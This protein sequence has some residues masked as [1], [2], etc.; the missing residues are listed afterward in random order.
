MSRCPADPVVPTRPAES[1]GEALR[2]A[3][4]IGWPVALK[5]AASGL[6]HKTEVGGIVLDL[7]E[8]EAL[9]AAYRDVSER[10]G[11]HVIVTA[12]V[13]RGVEVA[14]GV[15][16]DDQFGAMVMVAAGGVL[17]ELLQERRFVLP[18][19][20]HGRALEILN[21]LQIGHL[22][23]GLRGSPPADLDEVARTVVALSRLADDLGTAL[24][25]IDVNPL[26]AG[27]DGCVAVDALVIPRSQ[28]EQAS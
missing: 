17:I 4:E 8:E 23:R 7:S 16:R 18:P 22:L 12:M 5:T 9:L 1:P 10:L 3:E 2:A 14:L 13:P 24:D 6:A 28:H 19:V 27:P 26:V 11:P 20:D 15:V 25:A 21:R